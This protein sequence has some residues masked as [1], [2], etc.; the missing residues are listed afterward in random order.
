MK[1]LYWDSHDPLDCWDNPNCRWGD[2]SYRIEEGEPGYVPWFPPGYVPPAP[3]PRRPRSRHKAAHLAEP[4]LS[5]EANHDLTSMNLT[6]SEFPF[7]LR[8][9]Q[10][11]PG[12][13]SSRPAFQKEYLVSQLVTDAVA[14][15][16]A[17]GTTV[18][19][20]V[21]SAC[22]S[23]VF[24]RI[25]MA[26][27]E[28][29]K[30]RNLFGW[31]DFSPSTG[32]VVANPEGVINPTMI[33][34]DMNWTFHDE[35][36]ARFTSGVTTSR[37]AIEGMRTP[38]ITMVLRFDDHMPYRYTPSG[39]FILMGHEFGSKPDLATNTEV[40][41]FA[42]PEAGGA[43]VRITSYS[44]WTNSEIRGAWPTALTGRY[45]VRVVTLYRGA[46]ETRS[47]ETTVAMEP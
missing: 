13:W 31:G 1:T 5:S 9:N 43:P 8:P 14:D 22:A 4:D 7:Y 46:T 30:V 38:E 44:G 15:L 23:A 21:L 20:E 33:N 47:D 36:Y 18:S 40:G 16:A 12:T 3:A 27:R 37:I 19:E 29:R 6:N 34:V 24:D 11:N 45:F 28:A 26:G 41:V 39:G 17:K 35:G 42:V 25:M 2:P 10:S 32:G